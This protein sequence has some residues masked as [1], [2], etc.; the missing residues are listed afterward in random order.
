MGVQRPGAHH[1]PRAGPQGPEGRRRGIEGWGP[2]WEP[3]L[4]ILGRGQALG[5]PLSPGAQG[6]PVWRAHGGRD[7]SQWPQT[8]DPFLLQSP[9]AGVP[10]T[11]SPELCSGPTSIGRSPPASEEEN[12]TRLNFT[13]MSQAALL[14]LNPRQ[15]QVHGPKSCCLPD[16]RQVITKHAQGHQGYRFLCSPAV[17]PWESHITSLCLS[18]S[19]VSGR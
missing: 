8:P 16:M 12:F 15:P 6:S 17:W 18:F 2:S 7:A 10:Q 13:R 3:R 11:P 1:Q 19:S 5:A 14:S 4:A 9:P